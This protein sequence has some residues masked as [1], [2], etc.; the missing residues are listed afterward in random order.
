MG[1]KSP[2]T[3]P[4]RVKVFE[5]SSLTSIRYVWLRQALKTSLWDLLGGEKLHFY[6][7]YGDLWY[8]WRSN[9][10]QTNYLDTTPVSP[11]LGT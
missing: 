3:K 5:L 2:T 9:S 1:T 11:L 10:G 6:G 8:K 4:K 7:Y